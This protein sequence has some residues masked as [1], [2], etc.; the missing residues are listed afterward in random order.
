MTNGIVKQYAFGLKSE[1]IAIIQPELSIFLAGGRFNC[2]IIAVVGNKI[3]T[4]SDLDSKSI[5]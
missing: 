1:P 2:I 4:V 5:S 3:P